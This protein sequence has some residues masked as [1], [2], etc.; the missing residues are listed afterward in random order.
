VIRVIPYPRRISEFEIH[1][2][3]FMILKGLGYDIRGEV[4]AP[5]SRFDLVMFK[6]KEPKVVIEV[7]RLKRPNRFR[8]NGRRISRYRSYG[9]PVVVCLNENYIVDTIEKAKKYYEL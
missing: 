9:V 4:S 5:G 6:N 3:V 8:S 2:E 1:A 7:K